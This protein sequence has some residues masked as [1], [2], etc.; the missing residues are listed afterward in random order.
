MPHP[1]DYWTGER[2]Y[3]PYRMPYNRQRQKT[4]MGYE[5]NEYNKMLMQEHQEKEELKRRKE[6]SDKLIAES[7]GTMWDILI[8]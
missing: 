3:R 7:T 2:Y 8:A 1:I 5:I 4:L 6:I